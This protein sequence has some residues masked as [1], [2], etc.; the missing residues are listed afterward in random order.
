MKGYPEYR[1]AVSTA[2]VVILLVLVVII[3]SI[4]TVY[5]LSGKSSPSISSTATTQSTPSGPSPFILSTT[6]ANLLIAPGLNESY[7]TINIEPLSLAQ[8]VNLTLREASD[9]GF[10]VSIPQSTVEYNPSTSESVPFNFSVSPAV[11]PGDYSFTVEARYGSQGISQ[12]F[13][14]DVVPALVVM[15][16]EAFIPR[17]IT[18]PAGTTIVWMNIDTEIGCCDPG[19]HT[20]TF[21]LPNGTL[22][23]GMS[24]Q[25]LHRFDM[26][27]FTFE[28]AGTYHYYCTIHPN[29]LGLVNVTA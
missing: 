13:T 2:V 14:I 7:P 3:V 27:S 18:V 28:N 22:I 6:P 23:P 16:H 19:Y 4:S 9:P 20:V 25:V 29:M 10:Q 15:L 17:N 26:W 24:S 1:R 5:F 11:K 8:S 21:N 12:N